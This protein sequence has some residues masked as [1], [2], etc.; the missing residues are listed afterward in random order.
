MENMKTRLF[1]KYNIPVPR[2]TSYPTVPF[3]DSETYSSEGWANHIANLN[4]EV[5]CEKGISLYIHLPFCESLC[6]FCGCNKRITKNHNVEGAYIDNVLKEWKLYLAL[7]QHKPLIKE[8]HL[9]GGTPTFFSA[10][11]LRKLIS[12]ILENAQ[13]DSDIQMS[14]EGHPNHTSTE[15]LETLYQLGFR[16]ISFGVQDYDPIVQ[17]AI[18]RIQSFEQVQKVTNMA[19]AIGFTSISH[20]LVFGLPF[21]HIQ[22]IEDSIAKTLELTP[23]RISFYSYAHVPWI[24]GTGQRGYSEENLPKS[25]EKRALYER[26]KALLEKAGYLEVGF[27]HFALPSDELFMAMQN[28]TL[29]RNFMG[30]TTIASQTLIGLGVSAI[31]DG[32][33]AFSQNVKVVEE[34]EALLAIDKLPTERG[35][36][37]SD[38]D[39]I[40]QKQIMDLMCRFE[41]S[42]ENHP[43]LVEVILRLKPVLE[44]NLAKLEESTLKVLPNGIPFVRNICLALDEKYWERI[45][46]SQ[47]FS[48]AV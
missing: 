32:A 30:Y 14:L 18:H 24:K 31:S 20:D 44:D 4:K 5:L 35:H 45:P 47:L 34:Y 40:I 21:Q 25:T 7:F 43:Q 46:K 37:L 28:K 38:Q 39:A 15:H 29:H 22:S 11:N 19:R 16:R 2:Y 27:D 23:D 48:S 42:I 33:G 3:W 12:G 8:I 1:E 17:K 6:T 26:G 41:T 9:G 10:E 13:A 36:F